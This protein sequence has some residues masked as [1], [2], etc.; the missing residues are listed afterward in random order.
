MLEIKIGDGS[1]HREPEIAYSAVHDDG[2]TVR[3][4]FV[5]YAFH[6]LADAFQR[7][8]PLRSEEHTSELQSH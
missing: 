4:F 8:D 3:I 5:I 6:Q 1:Q 7:P 2:F